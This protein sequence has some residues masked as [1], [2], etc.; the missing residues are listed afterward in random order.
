MYEVPGWTAPK[1][2]A[3]KVTMRGQTKACIAKSLC[4][5][6]NLLIALSN[7]SFPAVQDN[8]SIQL[9]RSR[10]PKERTGHN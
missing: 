1:W 3:L 8:L 4:E 5:I 10:N 2:T 6:C 9:Q 7:N